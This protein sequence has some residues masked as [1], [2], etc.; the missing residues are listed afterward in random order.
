MNTT[1]ATLRA[2]IDRARLFNEELVLNG[3]TEQA[4]ARGRLLQQL[5]E[6]LAAEAEQTYTVEEAAELTGAHPETIRRMVREGEIE[7]HRST[8]GGTIRVPGSALDLIRGKVRKRPAA[9]ATRDTGVRA[10]AQLARL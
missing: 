10:V 6:L 1:T 7:D 2:F 8:P 9:S 3:A 5:E 4:K